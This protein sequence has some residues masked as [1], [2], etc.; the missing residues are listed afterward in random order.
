M[1]KIIPVLFLAIAL[2]NAVITAGAALYSGA[3]ER[4][5][6][7]NPATAAPFFR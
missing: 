6:L 7:V 1:A 4:H 2:I 3:V 5:G